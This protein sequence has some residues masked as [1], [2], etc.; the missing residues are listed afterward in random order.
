MKIYFRDIDHECMIVRKD[1]SYYTESG[2]LIYW[3]D[4]EQKEF[5]FFISA[6]KVFTK[7]NKSSCIYSTT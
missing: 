3:L 6:H 7:K 1:N 2:Q 4:R 5:D